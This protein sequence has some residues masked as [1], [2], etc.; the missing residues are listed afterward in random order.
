MQNGSP[1]PQ[2][3]ATATQEPTNGETLTGEIGTPG[4]SNTLTQTVLEL[5]AVLPSLL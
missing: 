4:V 2:Q 5:L 1:A 3:K